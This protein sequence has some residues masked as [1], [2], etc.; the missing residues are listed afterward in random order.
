MYLALLEKCPAGWGAMN[1][2][3]A[4]KKSGTNGLP[5]TENREGGA[6][7]QRQDFPHTF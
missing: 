2:S 3:T 7:C 1:E 6:V 5:E 4:G